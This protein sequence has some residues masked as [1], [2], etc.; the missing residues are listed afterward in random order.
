M[1]R[2]ESRPSRQGMWDYV[3]FLEIEGHQSDEQVA[4]A[5]TELESGASLYKILGSFPKAVL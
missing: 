3:F 2:I 5:L 4:Q 1:T